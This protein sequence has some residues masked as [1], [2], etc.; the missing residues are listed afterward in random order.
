MIYGGTKADNLK[1]MPINYIYSVM[2]SW[3]I[4][5]K[6]L[7]VMWGLE[8]ASLVSVNK[9]AMQ[10]IIMHPQKRIWTNGKDSAA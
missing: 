4:I 2:L 9:H 8:P 10:S 1:I 5:E 7:L 3:N 6:N